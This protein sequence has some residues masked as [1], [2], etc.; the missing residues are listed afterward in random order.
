MVKYMLLAVGQTHIKLSVEFWSEELEK[1]EQ[2][3]MSRLL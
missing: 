3:Y 1:I 2:K